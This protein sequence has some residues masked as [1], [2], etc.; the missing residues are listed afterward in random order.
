MNLE[1]NTADIIVSSRYPAMGETISINAT[2]H[3]TGFTDAKSVP[4]D[5]SQ[6]DLLLDPLP[7]KP[8]SFIGLR[9][10]QKTLAGIP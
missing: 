7:D 9:G 10:E 2:I 8:L 5:P 4:V 3:N 6:A 1:I